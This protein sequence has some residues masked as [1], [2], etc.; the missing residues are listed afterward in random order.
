MPNEDISSLIKSI[1]DD[2]LNNSNIF[3]ALLNTIS[4]KLDTLAEESETV[5]LVKI[6]LNDVT[7]MLK[8]EHDF[9]DE[10]FKKLED[11]VSNF[12]NKLSFENAGTLT[13]VD[14]INF[15]TDI[16]E[17]FSNLDGK[18]ADI[19]T[20]FNP[21]DS[22]KE[23]K[24]LLTGLP[25]VLKD[26]QQ[27]QLKIIEQNIQL[28]SDKLVAQLDDY[29]KGITNTVSEIKHHVKEFTNTEDMQTSLF[30]SMSEV[31]LHSEKKLEE[32][33]KALEKTTQGFGASL[34]D[35]DQDLRSMLKAINESD[36]SDALKPLA[37]E[38]ES[39]AAAVDAVKE[40]VTECVKGLEGSGAAYEK[41]LGAIDA[42]GLNADRDFAE[43]S[44]KLGALE[45]DLKSVLDKNAQAVIESFEGIDFGAVTGALGEHKIFINNVIESM[46]KYVEDIAQKLDSNSVGQLAAVEK[47][48]TD[49][50][51]AA[52]NVNLESDA[53]L[54]K[55]ELELHQIKGELRKVLETIG[56]LDGALT[57]K[58]AGIVHGMSVDINLG[59]TE[60]K[61]NALIE[62][63]KNLSG[64]ADL[65]EKIGRISQEVSLVNTDLVQVLEGKYKKLYEEFEPLKKDIR[66]FFDSG[67]N[68]VITELKS[69]LMSGFT[70]D[71]I[72][73]M[74][75]QV[76][77]V[78]SRSP[79]SITP[80]ME[81]VDALKL[82]IM[83]SAD[84]IDDINSKLDLMAI[85]D[86]TYFSE[87]GDQLNTLLADEHELSE[88]LRVV[89]GKIDLLMLHDDGDLSFRIDEIKK[90]INDQRKLLT[91]VISKEKVIEIEQRLDNVG[92]PGDF[93]NVK[94]S[95][96]SSIATVFDQISF[97]EE[98]E[99]IKDFVEEKT[100][101]INETLVKVNDQ[102]K[103]L[104]SE[105]D[106]SYT[107]Q[108][109]ESDIAKLQLLLK[110]G[111][112]ENLS[113]D[114]SRITQSID[115]L[116]SSLTQEQMCV[117]KESFEK[118]NEDIMSISTR[119]NKILIN[120]DESG[121]ILGNT[122]KQFDSVI[123]NLETRIQSTLNERIEQKLE[124]LDAMAVE[125]AQHDKVVHQ[126]LNYLGE[127]VDNISDK[128]D[129]TGAKAEPDID[130]EE[131]YERQQN[132]MDRLEKKLEAVLS[133]IENDE[134]TA[135]KLDKI[136]RQISKL[137]GDVEKLA[138]YVD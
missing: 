103:K 25:A 3:G 15:I 11:V 33:F 100:G 45:T 64:G 7:T 110:Q 104:V 12:E 68:G 37:K 34:F 106:Y 124:R 94:E 128:L 138:A 93:Y 88:V 89:H 107:L 90:L 26:E 67:C 121:K 46:R 114:M 51:D 32:K 122:L 36:N 77:N 13:K 63:V 70:E 129:G 6:Y 35:M 20:T 66:N 56:E 69:M 21:T 99:D 57:E 136:E 22:I 119:T 80:V 60:A 10:R 134:R 137:T 86:D 81:A 49:F 97:A 115:E 62:D 112:I 125:K 19:Y 59:D 38:I 9:T 83:R 28:L 27:P 39:I 84:K 116:S 120:S 61:L 5:D 131:L 17:E 65:E 8:S 29:E 87:I 53:R 23:I 58:L 91:S 71:I 82:N 74:K 44:D 76:N 40:S 16:K 18:I 118:I 109:V 96:L 4:S 111:S 133:A 105:E 14:I 73:E 54:A 50:I 102:L 135:R 42:N 132:R 31:Y 98:S 126:V 30:E 79:M 52:T 117:L 75:V 2:S 24:N 123:A 41:I 1:R 101:E 47:K 43:I 48:L 127:W 55:S 108:D 85:S 95:I 72:D 78:M 92:S 130:I 113:D